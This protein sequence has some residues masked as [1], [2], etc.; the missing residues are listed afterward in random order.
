MVPAWL[1]PKGKNPTFCRN[2]RLIK[3]HWEAE[4][5]IRCQA[6]PSHTD[7]HYWINQHK[8]RQSQWILAQNKDMVNS[9]QH[10]PTSNPEKAKCRS[11]HP[12]PVHSWIFHMD[13]LHPEWYWSSPSSLMQL[14]S[15]AHLWVSCQARH[16]VD[17]FARGSSVNSSC[18]SVL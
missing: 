10:C 12:T 14:H 7:L 13:A 11:N 17:A 2:H 3:A 15:P 18:W 5:R 8:E 16:D 6:V 9:W 4:C 1:S